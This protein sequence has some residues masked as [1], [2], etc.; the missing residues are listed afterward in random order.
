MSVLETTTMTPP[1]PAEKRAARLRESMPQTAK[2][3][4]AYWEENFDTLWGSPDVAA[5]LV[6]LGA[7]AAEMFDLSSK[8]VT[9]LAGFMGGTP[10]QPELDRL[11]AKVA[12]LPAYTIQP[13]GTVT[14]DPEV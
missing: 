11:L 8:Y 9:F 13:D 5:T 12:A 14:L 1:T 2:V 3:L 6:E 10:L 4:V 7:D